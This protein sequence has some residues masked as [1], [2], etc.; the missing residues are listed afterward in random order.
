MAHQEEVSLS[1][2]AIASI[3]SI[4]EGDLRSALQ[5]LQLLYSPTARSRASLTGG[6]QPP[7]QALQGS[8]K[9]V[10]AVRQLLGCL[11]SPALMLI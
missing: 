3:V 4:A 8:K 1:S 6:P 9:V 5:T 7:Q 10:R 11:G 2:A